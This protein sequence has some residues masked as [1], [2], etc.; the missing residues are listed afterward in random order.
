VADT[1]AMIETAVRR[2]QEEVPALAKLKLAFGLELRGRGDIQAFSVEVPGPRVTRGVPDHA[3]V[4][5]HIPRATFNQLAEDGSVA[6]YH[7]AFEEGHIKVEGDSQ[8]QKLIGQ[9]VERH[10]QRARLRKAH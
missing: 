8:I 7:R 6:A 3:R 1:K 9:V 10:E 4:T 5:V 2:F